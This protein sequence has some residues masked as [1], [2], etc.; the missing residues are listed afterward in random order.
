[1]RRTSAH[2][3]R[4]V[5]P[6][7][8]RDRRTND[9]EDIDP[10]EISRARSGWDGHSYD[11]PNKSSA[12]INCWKEEEHSHQGFD[13][14]LVLCIRFF[15]FGFGV[16]SLSTVPST[17]SLFL[18]IMKF[19]WGSTPDSSPSVGSSGES[20]VT[21]GGTLRSGSLF[22]VV[23]FEQ[24]SFESLCRGIIG[25]GQ[26][27][28]V[29]SDCSVASHS[30]RKQEWASL[31]GDDATCI[32]IRGGSVSSNSDTADTVFSHPIL[33]GA[34]VRDL[35]WSE[36]ELS[37][38]SLESWQATF[39]SLRQVASEEGEG[40]DPTIAAKVMANTKGEVKFAAM[41]PKPS[42]RAKVETVS[43]SDSEDEME[44]LEGGHP[45]TPAG[46]SSIPWKEVPLDIGSQQATPS[47]K[48]LQGGAWSNLVENVN[49]L[50]A[51]CQRASHKRKVMEEM[52][53][54]AIEQLNVKLSVL[55]ALLGVRPAEFGTDSA[56]SVLKHCVETVQT[57]RELLNQ[58]QSHQRRDAS[59][60]AK[61][62]ELE[63]KMDVVQSSS[64]SMVQGE[65]D[66]FFAD[67]SDFRQQFVNPTLT[68]LSRSS[69]NNADPGGKWAQMLE[70]LQAR[71]D[72]MERGGVSAST[73]PSGGLSIG[74]VGSFGWMSGGG[75]V[76]AAASAPTGATGMLT[77][78]TGSALADA[79]AELRRM[80]EELQ[81]VKMGISD[82]QEQV[83]NEAI[84][85]GSIVFPSRTFCVSWLTLHHAESDP[86]VFV[87]AV[88]LLSLATSDMSLDE[89]RAANKRATTAKV[90]DKTPYHT[91]Y[92]ASFNLDVPPLL[93]KGTDQSQTTN[94]RALGGVPKFEDFHPPSGREGI[95]QRILDHVRDGRQTLE[96]A[97]G[98]LFAFGTAP[99]S[100]AKEMLHLSK[101][102]WDDLC[103]W[104]V[105]YHQQVQ[106]ESEASEQEVW[107]LIS[108][109]VRAVFKSLREARAP[110][111][112]SNTPAGML[113]GTLKA[114][115]VMKEYRAAEF[116]G[117]PKIALILHEHLI[118]FATPRSKFDTLKSSLEERLEKLQRSVNAAVSASNKASKKEKS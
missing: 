19:E 26:R 110:G 112:A 62:E 51:D 102:F 34:C 47:V 43:S 25:T 78:S 32:F 61:V 21:G 52:Q 98:E 37:P 99:S 14:P 56:F 27:V 4:I 38:R 114:H 97:I 94:S 13:H 3:P 113:W 115:D 84:T 12:I 95:H 86:H 39:A 60:L 41:T 66:K 42:K 40:V 75:S 116:S 17:S 30:A 11:R 48:V 92:I 29:R 15:R 85:V 108:H 8:R 106:A 9:E 58:N 10:S 53:E 44:L 105:R 18:F 118:R 64:K 67:Q 70:N 20:L 71:M 63:R 57:V 35:D 100:V 24:S 76:G 103:H 79:M 89:D 2:A 59:L 111:R 93:G 31:V 5:P 6:R 55:H 33:P 45:R 72:A 23:R 101:A 1:M 36:M 7:S 50:K 109:C 77:G 83:D 49:H 28:C 54:E 22:G 74:G 104:M 69:S 87:D 68:L 107:I 65:L 80:K 46:R 88:S 16:F 117:H 90:R 73:A 81:E 91:A 96:Q 82:L